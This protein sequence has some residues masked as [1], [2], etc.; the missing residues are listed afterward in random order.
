MEKLLIK[1]LNFINSVSPELA[2]PVLMMLSMSVDQIYEGLQGPTEEVDKFLAGLNEAKC[3]EVLE[4]Y[5]SVL[6]I[7]TDREMYEECVRIVFILE[8][9]KLH[10]QSLLS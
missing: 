2:G 10:K 4:F 8:T 5:N 7:F 9:V 6:E 1:D 3:D